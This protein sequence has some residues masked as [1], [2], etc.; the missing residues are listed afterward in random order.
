[1]MKKD[2][3]KIRK[4]DYG[5]IRSQQRKR[6]LYT[7]LAFIAPLSVF[8]TG[9]YINRTRNSIF[10]V[11]AVVACLPACKFAV[12][13]IMMF[14][15]KPMSRADYL[16][17]EKHKRGLTCSYELAVTAYEKQSFLDSLAV[18]GNTVAGYASSAKT[19]TAFAE[20]H[21]QSILKQNGYHVSVKI[22]RRLP[23]YT[24]RLDSMWDHRESLEKDIKFKPDEREPE[25]TRNEKIMQVIYAI[26]L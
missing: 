8:F 25:V 11:V 17:I 2:K 5:Y 18:C 20:K 24:A 9:L 6:V 3:R 13:M 7:L 22:F 23:D 14:L 12:G 15:Q 4:G 21:I 10:T 16:E 26:S 1:M 19:D